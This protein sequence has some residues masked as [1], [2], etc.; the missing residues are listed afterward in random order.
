MAV[1]QLVESQIVILVVVGSSPISHPK[2]PKSLD[3]SRLFS[4]K[5]CDRF[6][7]KRQ[8]AQNGLL[9]PRTVLLR[10]VTWAAN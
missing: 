1:A 9:I 6:P 10:S 7:L 8:L 5:T 4:F 3:S 2:D